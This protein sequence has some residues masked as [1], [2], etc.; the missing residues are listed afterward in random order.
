MMKK[1]SAAARVAVMLAALAAIA[2]SA[3]GGALAAFADTGGNAGG[4]AVYA[5]AGNEGWYALISSGAL[6]FAMIAVKL[7][8][9]NRHRLKIKAGLK[10]ADDMDPLL[11]GKLIDN[12]AHDTD[13]AALIF[14]PQ[15]VQPVVDVPDQ[16]VEAHV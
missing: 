10:A 5:A 16:A 8:F 9:F 7:I 2:A 6:L 14:Y 3:F 15:H 4:A 11:V 12:K 1:T 13:L